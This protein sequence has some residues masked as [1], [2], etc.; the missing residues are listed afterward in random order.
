V[1]ED[2][3]E[4]VPSTVQLCLPSRSVALDLGPRVVRGLRQVLLIMIWLGVWDVALL[5]R[6]PRT[7]G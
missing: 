5:P 4:G 1:Q 2:V 3:P 7:Q 6:S